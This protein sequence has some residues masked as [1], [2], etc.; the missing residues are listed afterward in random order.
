MPGLV[1][2]RVYPRFL[3]SMLKKLP[4]GVVIVSGTNGKTTTT[5]ILTEL[6]SSQ[7]KR[8]LTNKTGGNFVRGVISTIANAASVWGKLPY[9]VAVFE[10]DEAYAVRFVK[11]YKPRAVVLLNVTRDQ[12]DRFGEIDTTAQL[13][14]K[15]VDQVTELAVLN[16]GD[17]RINKI[18]LPQNVKPAYFGIND[19]L[20]K[21]F[22]NDEEL[23]GK[24]PIQLTKHQR[25]V[26]LENVSGNDAT[27][28]IWEK[29]F[30]ATLQ[31]DGQHNALNGAAALAATLSLYP[32]A[33][34]GQ[35]LPALAQI[36]A[37][38]GRGEIIDYQGKKLILQLIKNPA[39]FRQGLHVLDIHKPAA[40]GIII[41]DDHADGRDVSWLWDID[42]TSLN[43]LPIVT[44]GTR[45]FDMANRL[46][47]D[48]VKTETIEADLRKMIEKV[49]SHAQSGQSIIIFATYTAMLEARKV[50][51][52]MTKV[53]RI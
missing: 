49:A 19:A 39:S 13:L 8:V 40:I 12:L 11:L 45:G 27:Y 35:L 34:P 46:K 36:K 14:Q 10:Q 47:Y 42:F 38:F 33:D 44:S 7:N 26:E 17:T 52:K 9:D 30:K 28:K 22:P 24:S 6:L 4:D 21:Q 53:E 29:T 5:K 37:A 15:V 2:E 25:L 32:K 43:A 16:D 1:I 31:A 20:S 48:S 51:S 3:S 23:Y 41:N 18:T 50:I